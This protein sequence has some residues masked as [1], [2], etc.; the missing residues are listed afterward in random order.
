MQTRTWLTEFGPDW[1]VPQEITSTLED[2]SDG[3]DVEPSFIHP[4]ADARKRHA[5]LFAEHPDQAR[6]ELDWK[7]YT[8]IKTEEDGTIGDQEPAFQTD[9]L[10]S[11]LGFFK[12]LHQQLT[13]PK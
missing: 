11:A 6:R 8:V 12:A 7:R 2:T 13:T 10:P 3:N 5:V 4:E 9:H 1:Q